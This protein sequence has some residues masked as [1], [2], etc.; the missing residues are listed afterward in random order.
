M[1]WLR[2]WDADGNMLLWSSEQAD[3]ERQR[4]NKL[5]EKLRELGVNPDEIAEKL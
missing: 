3:Q 2:W 1:N 4:A 5:A